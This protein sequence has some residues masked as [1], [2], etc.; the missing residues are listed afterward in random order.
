MKPLI[1]LAL[2]LSLAGCAT[3]PQLTTEQADDIKCRAYGVPRGSPAY[4][5]C[6]MNVEN[7][8]TAANAALVGALATM[9]SRPAPTTVYVAPQGGLQADTSIF[10]H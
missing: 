10:T 8:R 6:R 5:Q 3:R 9:Q 7:D 4:V 1:L 2:A